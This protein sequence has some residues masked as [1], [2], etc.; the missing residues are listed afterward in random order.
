MMALRILHSKTHIP[1][2]VNLNY[3]ILILSDCI[4]REIITYKQ[5]TAD[6]SLIE[7][8]FPV[9][10]DSIYYI[11]V[12]LDMQRSDSVCSSSELSSYLRYKLTSQF[13][14]K[15]IVPEI[16][17]SQQCE[18]TKLFVSSYYYNYQWLKDDTIITDAT[19]SYYKATT[20]GSYA[21][22]IS[23]AQCTLQT[24]PVTVEI[25]E[26]LPT[27]TISIEGYE[28]FCKD[29]TLILRTETDT[30]YEIKWRKD[31]STITDATDTFLIIDEPGE[32]DLRLYDGSCYSE[33]S[34]DISQLATPF[35]YSI[36]TD[37]L[38][39]FYTMN[40]TAQ[41]QKDTINEYNSW[42]SPTATVADR[43]GNETGA[44]YLN[45]EDDFF[46]PSTD[47]SIG[48]E[49]TVSIWI[50]TTTNYGGSIISY[51]RS[52]LLYRNTTNT[53]L[54]YLSDDG[55]IHYLLED[56]ITNTLSS[57]DSYNDGNWH[58]ITASLSAEGAK[59][60]IDA[61]LI[62]RNE[63]VTTLESTSRKWHCA[64]S[65][66]DDIP[67]C[68]TNQ[69]FEG[70]IDELA[71]YKKELP[72]EEIKALYN[73]GYIS[74]N[75]SDNLI[76]SGE[77][78]LIELPHSQAL[79][80]YQLISDSGNIG[81]SVSGNGD[82][83]TLTAEDLQKDTCIYLL[84]EHSVSGCKYTFDKA[85]CFNV[86]DEFTP[87]LQIISDKEDN[88]IY[89]NQTIVFTIEHD[90]MPGE[91]TYEWYKNDSLQQE[92]SADLEAAVPDQDYFYAVLHTTAS[93]ATIDSAVS[94]II[95][96][97][98][99][100]GK[101]KQ[102]LYLN[103]GW[104]LISLCVSPDSTEIESIF[105]HVVIIKND[106]GFYKINQLSYLNSISSIQG[107]KAYLLFNNVEENIEITGSELDEG[108]ISSFKQGWNMLG[109]PYMNNYSLE[110]LPAETEI[111]KNFE[112]FYILGEDFNSLDT[113]EVGKGYFIKV[114]NDSQIS[115]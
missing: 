64:S 66:S 101:I 80:N 42:S 113:L 98:V 15:C 3:T 5:G 106:E 54:L 26:T 45:G 90:S 93:C 24:E 46:T 20:P 63:S 50:Q 57:T 61:E 115:W 102:E 44:K 95:T 89:E 4:T 27:P 92:Q 6:S 79:V 74:S 111:I 69:Y 52:N 17:I 11:V 62:T 75:V 18:Y 86:I 112:A 71:I 88:T 100:E 37:K 12:E 22:R 10:E 47:N 58:M 25:L 81:T 72:L 1:K 107:G 82:A 35:D 99:L 49:F 96:V 8:S 65:V 97:T 60:Y 68:P 16:Q 40:S 9:K 78:A 108:Y 94:N 83:I 19:M 73:Y 110:I 55:R 36:S 39:C 31:N 109:I 51:G 14:K 28:H 114:S 56:S 76:C 87:S 70:A 34:V 84:A 67:D 23:L 105:P 53:I 38:L 13:S 2:H 104:N 85:V 43:H 30:S 59:L 103:E 41:L 91:I 77:D 48:D 29:S 32:Y 7:L 33:E 21:L